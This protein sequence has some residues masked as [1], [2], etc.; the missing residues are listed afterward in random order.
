MRHARPKAG[1]LNEREIMG[2]IIGIIVVGAIIGALARLF[3]KGKEPMGIVVTIIIG[4]VG[5]GLAGWVLGLLGYGNAN[6][7]I[8]WIQWIVAVIFAII[9]IGIYMALTGKKSE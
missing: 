5:A 9:L 6:G 2:H 1:A 7:G 3:R 4:A 8:P